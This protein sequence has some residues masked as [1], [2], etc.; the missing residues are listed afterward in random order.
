[1]IN[2]FLALY[3]PV[4]EYS[5]RNHEAAIPIVTHKQYEV[6]QDI[7]TI[8][9]V[10]Q[11][12]QQL[13][14]AE[15]TPTLSLALPVYETVLELWRECWELFPELSLAIDGAILKIQEYVSKSR[16]SPVHVLAMFVNPSLKLN[17]INKHWKESQARD[18]YRVVESK[19]LEYVQET[20]QHIFEP[21]PSGSGRGSSDAAK[22]QANGYRALLDLNGKIHRADGAVP[23]CHT[24]RDASASTATT[25]PTT[26]TPEQRA[27]HNLAMVQLEIAGYIAE[28]VVDASDA[29]SGI[30]IVSHWKALRFTYPLIHRLAMDILPVQ[31]SSVSSERVFS[32]SKLTCT[33]ERGRMSVGT[34]ESLQVLKNSIQRRRVPGLDD[35]KLDF[36]SKLDVP[37]DEAIE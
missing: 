16:R 12:A 5:L 27:A 2:R 15:R 11:H 20:H 7:S 18:A 31:A 6:L 37:G 26:L 36:M 9:S 10:A 32:S 23:P 25:L 3:L 24:S 17:W 34:V 29:S 35:C 22:A 4:T 33:R 30:D 14:S 13:L 28:G 21:S 1:M 19:L 8:L